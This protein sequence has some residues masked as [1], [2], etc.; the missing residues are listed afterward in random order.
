MMSNTALG[1]VPVGAAEPPD[2][3]ASTVLLPIE[4]RLTEPVVV[5]G[6]GLRAI[7]VPAVILV[8]VPVPETVAQEGL[9]AG[10][11]EDRT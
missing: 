10:P 3:L 2:T 9:A 5:I 6:D 7:P 4:A 1:V 8:T 11:P